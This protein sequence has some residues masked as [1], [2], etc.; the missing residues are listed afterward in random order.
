[1]HCYFSGF[2]ESSTVIQSM[3]NDII[4]KFKIENS[5]LILGNRF[6]NYKNTLKNG[7]PIHIFF[8]NIVFKSFSVCTTFLPF[9]RPHLCASL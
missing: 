8:G 9:V 5:D 3:N 1:M 4:K 6:Y 7:M 2:G